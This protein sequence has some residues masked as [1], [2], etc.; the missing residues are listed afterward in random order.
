MHRDLKPDNVR[1]KPAGVPKIADFGLAERVHVA[2]DAP[3]QHFSGTPKFMAP[4]LFHGDAATT[5]SDIYAL[6]VCYFYLLTGDFSFHGDSFST[7]MQAVLTEPVPSIRSRCPDPS[8]EMAECLGLMLAKSPENRPCNADAA[9]QLLEAVLGLSRD[10]NSLLPE[11]FAAESGILWMCDGHVYR[12]TV[13][14]PNARRQRVFGENSGQSPGEQL[15]MIYS[16]CYP[17]QPE[18]YEE[19]LRLNSQIP[20]GGLSIRDIDGQATFVMLNNYPCSTIDVG[21]LRRRV[22]EVATRADDIKHLLTHFDRH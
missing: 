21:E 3:T 19:S 2:A 17:D 5:I 16:K 1:V 18:Y 11:A 13:S 8:F 12:L 15:V 4:E 14:L 22:I 9:G 10:I 7:L 6:G 20:H